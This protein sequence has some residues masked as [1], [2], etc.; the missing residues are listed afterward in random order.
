MLASATSARAVCCLIEDLSSYAGPAQFVYRASC[1][2]MRTPSAA[3]SEK[4]SSPP[5]TSA[6]DAAERDGR[7]PPGTIGSRTKSRDRMGRDAQLHA[8]ATPAAA[9]ALVHVD[10]ALVT[11]DQA[12]SARRPV[13]DSKSPFDRCR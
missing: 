2:T 5:V 6:V 9:T 10:A 11:F 3:S 12:R 1:R 4:L 8:Q 13:S 7:P